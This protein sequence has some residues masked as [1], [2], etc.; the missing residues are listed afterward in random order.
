MV[1]VTCYD[2]WR[3]RRLRAYNAVAPSSI[4]YYGK[5]TWTISILINLPL[6][7]FFALLEGSQDLVPL[8]LT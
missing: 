4:H 7:S 3:C 8:Y 5:L 2:I 1:L 6:R